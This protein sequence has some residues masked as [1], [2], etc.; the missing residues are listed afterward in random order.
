MNRFY[1][2][3]GEKICTLYAADRN[4]VSYEEFDYLAD[5]RTL[6]VLYSKMKGVVIDEGIVILHGAVRMGGNGLLKLGAASVEESVGDIQKLQHLFRALSIAKLAFFDYSG[7]YLMRAGEKTLFVSQ[8]LQSLDLVVAGNTEVLAT[9]SCSFG[10]FV[11]MAQV[12]KNRFEV[13][14]VAAVDRESPSGLSK[15]FLNI[16]SADEVEDEESF[17]HELSLFAYTMTTN[18]EAYKVI[19]E[20]N[21]GQN[22]WGL[23]ESRQGDSKESGESFIRA[24]IQDV[25]IAASVQNLPAVVGMPQDKSKEKRKRFLMKKPK[26]QPADANA[27]DSDELP[28][29][30]PKRRKFGLPLKMSLFLCFLMPALAVTSKICVNEIRAI[31]ERE[32]D[33]FYQINNQLTT[34][35]AKLDAYKRI[36]KSDAADNLAVLRNFDAEMLGSK[37]KLVV[38]KSDIRVDTC[39]KSRQEAESFVK[40]LKGTYMVNSSEIAKLDELWNCSV[41]IE[42]V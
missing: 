3:L 1:I 14:A 7:F 27:K 4:I 10:A 25:P 5:A 6:D 15:Y 17:M 37:T 12:L 31:E 29:Q 36:E 40:Y 20:E 8:R 26:T 35:T 18:S 2:D 16:G 19:I 23:Q 28:A 30:K 34:D 33:T 11:N 39:Y 13:Q 21:I 24:G 41:E 32:R 22:G 38:E 42:I 9:E